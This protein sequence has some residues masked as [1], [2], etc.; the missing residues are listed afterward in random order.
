MTLERAKVITEI[1]TAW[2]GFLG[3]LVAGVFAAY[4]Y[5]D[6]E[7]ADRVKYVLSYVDRYNQSPLLSAR[8]RVDEVWIRSWARQKDAL[9]SGVN[10][11]G[12]HRD[13]VLAT[14]DS[15]INTSD[16]HLQLIFFEQLSSCISAKICD[17][18]TAKVFFRDDAASFFNQHYPWISKE[19]ADRSDEAFGKQ[20]QGFL[21]KP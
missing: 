18:K 17:E 10:A 7:Q 5:V 12:M 19:R 2:L 15:S 16:L 1:T 11:E 14:I 20:L 9:K 4:Q 13:F 21:E 6:N 8:Q 3:L